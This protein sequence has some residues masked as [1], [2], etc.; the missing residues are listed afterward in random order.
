[1]YKQEQGFFFFFF[2]L[3]LPQ[4]QGFQL[5]TSCLTSSIYL[6]SFSPRA[7]AASQGALIT[8]TWFTDSRSFSSPSLKRSRV[9]RLA[10]AAREHRTH[11]APFREGRERAS[12]RP[13]RSQRYSLA[14]NKCV[15][16]LFG[17]R[18]YKKCAV[19]GNPVHSERHSY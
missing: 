12:L 7:L 17:E 10:Q 1:M 15:W 4:Q 13:V 5:T 16:K 2:R 14:V 8:C 3:H 6:M 18:L 19:W 9:K 11:I